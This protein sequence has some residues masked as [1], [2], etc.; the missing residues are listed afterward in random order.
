MNTSAPDLGTHKVGKPIITCFTDIKYYLQY[1]IVLHYRRYGNSLVFYSSNR[2]SR[3]INV[4][5]GCKA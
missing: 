4:G 5:L 2:L 3:D 1:S